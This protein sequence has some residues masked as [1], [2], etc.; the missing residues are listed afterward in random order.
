MDGLHVAF[1]GRIGQ[2]PERRFTSSG[3]EILQFSVLPA[4][5]KAGDSP[6]WVKCSIFVDKLEEYTPGKLMKGCEVYIEGRL[7]LGRWNGQDGAQRSGLNV[8]A[9]TVHPMG[10]IGRRAPQQTNQVARRPVDVG[11]SGRRAWPPEAAG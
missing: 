7:R 10:A 4:D 6:E 1:V 2:E 3:T 8:N 9:W 5:S 11:A